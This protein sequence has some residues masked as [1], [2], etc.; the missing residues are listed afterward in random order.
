[1]SYK[2]LRGRQCDIVLN[3][4]ALT[5][6]AIDDVKNFSCGELEG[7]FDGFSKYHNFVRSF[8]CQSKYGRHFQTNNWE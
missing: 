8:Q 6:D 3:V 1:M 5:E 2:I 7:I 4:F